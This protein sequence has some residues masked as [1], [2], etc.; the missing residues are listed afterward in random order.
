MSVSLDHESHGKSPHEPFEDFPYDAI[1]GAPIDSADPP[2]ADKSLSSLLV[3]LFKILDKGNTQKGVVIRYQTLKYL[4]GYQDQPGLAR[5][6]GVTKAAISK[7]ARQV[8]SEL[9]I[10]CHSMRSE[11]TC[12][13]FSRQTAQR[14][15]IRKM[16]QLNPHLLT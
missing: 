1:D 4:C 12:E 11:E 3:R 16:G 13:Q 7:V 15:A 8:A 14:H 5:E 9:G 10:E 6:L 2:S